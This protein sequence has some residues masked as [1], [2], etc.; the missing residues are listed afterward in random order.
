MPFTVSDFQDLLE[1]LQQHP[2]WR[3]RLLQTLLGE[4]P[5]VLLQQ[6]QQRMEEQLTALTTEVRLLA[7]AQRRTEQRVE[8]LVTA[9][10]LLSEEFASYRVQTDQALRE[11]AEAQRLLSE[12]FASY[13]VQT[14]QAL[15][16]LA[17]A[18]R[19]L[20][21]EFASYRVQTDQALREL[22]EAQRLLS[23]EFA[24]YRVQT[25]QA[26]RELAEAQRHT[27][28]EFVA[29]RQSTDL[30]LDELS[31]EV[32]NLSARVGMTLEEEAEDMV[33]WVL[34]QK[35]YRF[36]EARQSVVFD[37]ELDVVLIGETPTGKRITVLIESKTRL[38]RRDVFAWAQRVQSEGFRS[39]LEEAGFS[40]P[41]LPY[42]FAMRPDPA[43]VEAAQEIG[44]G[45]VT[46][47]GLQVEGTV[48]VPAG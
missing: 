10:R 15:R 23:E 5:L 37:G 40:P 38:G 9:Q 12:E 43:A 8:E 46:S 28:E 14:D 17:E 39:R 4:P 36:A 16:E 24:S 42:L 32:K 1:I 41:Y 47:R 34:K 27:Y 2:E 30:R 13:R 25:D 35:G 44:I 48:V 7:E 21:E 3:A 31:R 19:L 18:Q 11:L 6:V 26:L 33:W 45:L 29:Y 20:S 22:A